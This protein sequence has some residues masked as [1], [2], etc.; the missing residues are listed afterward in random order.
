MSNTT[1]ILLVMTFLSLCV[2]SGLVGAVIAV[3]Y[4]HRMQPIWEKERR[5]K[6]KIQRALAAYKRRNEHTRG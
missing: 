1:I 5:A 3:D 4:I 2:T 6:R